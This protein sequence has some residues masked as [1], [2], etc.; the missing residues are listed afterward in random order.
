MDKRTIFAVV[1]SALIF[2]TY[3]VLQSVLFPPKPGTGTEGEGAATPTPTPTPT[4]MVSAVPPAED[5]AVAEAV[6]AIGE[7]GTLPETTKVIHTGQFDITF[8]NRGAVATSILLNDPEADPDNT[9]LDDGIQMVYAGQNLSAVTHPVFPFSLHFGS[10]RTPANSDLYAV[11]AESENG[12]TFAREFQIE[13]ESVT[14]IK[15]FEVVPGEYLVK[16]FITIKSVKDGQRQVIPFNF[17]QFGRLVPPESEPGV[18]YTLGIEPQIGPKF[19]DVTPDDR[20]DYRRFIILSSSGREEHNLGRGSDPMTISGVFDWAAVM[21]KYY[22]IIGSTPNTPL[23]NLVLDA[24][25][26]NLPFLRSAMYFER[27]REAIQERPDEYV[28]YI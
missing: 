12:I 11:T 28:F 15:R 19:E 3:L 16:L 23:K 8:S 20:T 6:Y 10:F 14:V 26:K 1:I 5:P 13:K 27:Q 25:E 4:S 2:V 7:D 22:A 18:M 24:R 17:D 21:G 9:R